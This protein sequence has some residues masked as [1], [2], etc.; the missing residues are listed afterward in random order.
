MTELGLDSIAEQC[1]HLV[2]S[3]SDCFGPES[4]Q[5]LLVDSGGRMLVTGDGSLI[6]QA[7]HASHP[8]GRLVVDSILVQTQQTGDHSKTMILMLTE[9][10]L[11]IS[12]EGSD[13][14]TR[15]RYILGLHKVVSSILPHVVLPSLLKDQELLWKGDSF[16]AECCRVL[17]TFLNG[18]NTEAV[19][20]ILRNLVLTYLETN[21]R[22][23]SKI[24][25]KISENYHDDSAK[26]LTYQNVGTMCPGLLKTFGQSTI[27]SFGKPIADSRILEGLIIERDFMK[28]DNQVCV[29]SARF[30]L[31]SGSID[32]LNI[33]SD[34]VLDLSKK[35]SIKDQ[36]SYSESQVDLCVSVMTKSDVNLLISSDKISS[37]VFDR[38]QASGIFVCHCVDIEDIERLSR[39]SC[40]RIMYCADDIL[41][42]LSVGVAGQ[43]KNLVLGP[44]KVIFFEDIY[45]GI[46]TNESLCTLVLNGPTQGICD[47]YVNTVLK[48]LKCINMWLNEDDSS[49]NYINYRSIQEQQI[50][51][52]SEK[53]HCHSDL[54]D[55]SSNNG[56]SRT[57][58]GIDVNDRENNKAMTMSTVN[59]K[60][61]SIDRMHCLLVRG[62]G[63]FEAAVASLL[64]NHSAPCRDI[65]S[66]TR[67]AC[68]VLA[69]ALRTVP[70]RLG[71]LAKRG[72]PSSEIEC[73]ESL[74]SKLVAFHH[75]IQLLSQLLRL[76]SVVRVKSLRSIKDDEESE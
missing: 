38:C 73:T 56:Y 28:N 3:I 1:R 6:F 52:L 24:S 33:E 9:A 72:V 8:I 5:C 41:T 13:A 63:H 68:R 53:D 59:D 27:K 48:C 29:K 40:A 62:G 51:S 23:Q 60:P 42:D 76:E 7:L 12:R 37:L 45:S 70:A 16:E 55:N 32:A 75:V 36:F 44:H 17:D 46:E 74:T 21:L 43:C 35:C 19:N 66:E 50:Q 64:L 58:E 25:F 69:T 67:A 57:Y 30:V 34:L 47:G 54:S 2:S 49:L 10:L 20:T 14:L 65:D 4:G 15:Q 61:G 26:N 11:E 39:I 18:K 71:H 22:L 31:F